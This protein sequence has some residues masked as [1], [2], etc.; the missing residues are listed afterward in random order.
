MSG[1]AS[2]TVSPRGSGHAMAWA[3]GIL[4]FIL[5]AALVSPF[6]GWQDS[7]EFLATTAC[8]GVSHPGGQPLYNLLGKLFLFLP[9]GT[10]AWDLGLMS[11][12]AAAL[13]SVLLFFLIRRVTDLP[14]TWSALLVMAWSLSQ[15]WWNQAAT[16]ETYALGLVH[17]L[18]VLWAFDQEGEKRWPLTGFALGL[19]ALYRPTF[20]V[21][22]LALPLLFLASN[23]G[24]RL[25]RFAWFTF[26]FFTAS[27]LAWYLAI[28]SNAPAPILFASLNH[29]QPLVKYILGLSYSKNLGGA[30]WNGAW[31]MLGRFVAK[32]GQELTPAGLGLAV[33]GLFIL[34]KDWRKLPWF[35]PLALLWALLDLGL[36]LTVPFPM[37]ESHQVIWPYA[38]SAIPAAAGLAWLRRRALTQGFWDRWG[39]PLMSLWVLLQCANAGDLWLKRSDRA[40]EDFARDTLS[41][42]KPGALYFASEDND[43]FPVIGVQQGYGI[44]KDV[45]IVSPVYLSGPTQ[46]R[47]RDAIAAGAP[48]YVTKLVSGLGR[49]WVYIPTGPLYQVARAPVWIPVTGM[50]PPQV[51]GWKGIALA[52]AAPEQ[53]R[54]Q[55]GGVL[56]LRYEWRKTGGAPLPPDLQVVVLLVDSEGKYPQ[57]DGGPWLHDIHDWLNDWETPGRMKT[58]KTYAYDRWLFVPSNF[59]PGKYRVAVGLQV[60]LP[61]KSAIPKAGGEFYGDGTW[62]AAWRVAGRGSWDSTMRF[63]T[64]S[65]DEVNRL[66]PVT[67]PGALEGRF[68]LAG[69]V[70]IDPAE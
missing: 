42:M 9:F 57:V 47:L 22:G 31:L 16:V 61:P 48:V 14:D 62:Q 50:R 65:P 68:I 43:Y 33:L 69:E 35:V 19:A 10:P 58:G 46:D 66:L 7:G 70:E 40:A 2:T 27:R 32:M 56:K 59:P 26:A 25:K 49:D 5:N 4:L 29:F 63:D 52:G 41:V 3:L 60:P 38:V 39:L 54:I 1:K 64:G 53:G 17:T 67:S 18:F 44:R 45:Q 23:P 8:L 28:R 15:P 30:G 21:G 36:V 6:L 11:S 12:A 34:A 20:L 24:E 37:L 51:G 13:A 55:A